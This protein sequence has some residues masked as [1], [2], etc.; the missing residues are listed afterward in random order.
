MSPNSW[1]SGWGVRVWGGGGG[2]G[3]GCRALPTQFGSQ[4][5]AVPT[6]QHSTIFILTEF[7]VEEFE[8]GYLL[9]II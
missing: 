5:P 4:E 1:G 3:S 6:L 7:L 8:R 2:G 9:E